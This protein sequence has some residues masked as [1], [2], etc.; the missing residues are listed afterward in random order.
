MSRLEDVKAG[1]RIVFPEVPCDSSVGSEKYRSCV[2]GALEVL[3]RR[4][5][6]SKGL[7][8]RFQASALASWPELEQ[9][10]VAR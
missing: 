7:A 2:T 8:E 6:L 10:D 3:E 5:L 9:C 1:E 4:G